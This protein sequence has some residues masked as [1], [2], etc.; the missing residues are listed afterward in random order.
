M[1]VITEALLVT[2]VA[3]PAFLICLLPMVVAEISVMIETLPVEFLALGLMTVGTYGWTF[4][5]VLIG[6]VLKR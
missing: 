5:Q 4:P 3:H 2:H 1:T 6:R